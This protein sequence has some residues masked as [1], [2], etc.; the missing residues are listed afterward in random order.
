MTNSGNLSGWMEHL[1]QRPERRSMLGCWRTSKDF[2]G[3]CRG[4]EV[5]RVGGDIREG[6]GRPWV[7]PMS[8]TVSEAIIVK[9]LAFV[10][11]KMESHR[12]AV[13]KSCHFAFFLIPTKE[14]YAKIFSGNQTVPGAWWVFSKYLLNG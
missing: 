13:S 2:S 11:R 3:C 14:C 12:K 8:Y 7:G 9:C 10:L 6:K 4:D 1:V 5:R